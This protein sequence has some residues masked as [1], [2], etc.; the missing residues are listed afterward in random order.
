MHSF[1]L[2]DGEYAMW[3]HNG[4]QT[5]DEGANAGNLFGAHPFYLNLM[6]ENKWMGVFFLSPYGQSSTINGSTV[7]HKFIG[8][9]IEMFMWMA[10]SAQSVLEQYH[11]L[12]GLPVRPPLWGLGVHHSRTGY[13]SVQEMVEVVSNF[14]DEGIP[15]D[16]MWGDVDY[17][18]MDDL[19]DFQVDANSQFSTLLMAVSEWSVAGIHWVPTVLPWFNS[20]NSTWYY[21]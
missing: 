10:E 8:G 2:A 17:M 15:L 14:T 4:N 3:N 9:N 7:T 11:A 16:G 6:E 21:Y 12:I 5:Y 20:A 19:E 18:G 13:G 1:R